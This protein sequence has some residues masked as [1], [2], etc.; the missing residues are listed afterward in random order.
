MSYT[1]IFQYAAIG[2]I[3]ISV[4]IPL[5]ALIISTIRVRKDMGLSHP[6]K[7]IRR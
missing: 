4:S 3:F 1:E 7:K 2:V 5:I 6:K